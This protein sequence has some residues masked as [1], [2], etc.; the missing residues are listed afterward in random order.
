VVC[1]ITETERG[2]AS[3]GRDALR[4]GERGMRKKEPALPPAMP[5]EEYLRHVAR[6]WNDCR[7]LLELVT[8]ESA[9]RYRIIP[10]REYL[11]VRGEDG[12]RTA[13][14]ARYPWAP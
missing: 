2:S 8:R 6:T 13:G 12:K 10:Q 1:E 9:P 11:W 3:D 7:P 14:F 4:E 5:D